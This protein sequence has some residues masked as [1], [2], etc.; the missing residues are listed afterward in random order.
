LKALGLLVL[1]Q[2]A[3]SGMLVTTPSGS[4]QILHLPFAKVVCCSAEGQCS[5]SD[6]NYWL[7][8]QHF[9]WT[10]H[11]PNNC[12]GLLFFFLFVFLGF[13]SLK[14]YFIVLI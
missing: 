10:F 6:G 14:L 7:F 8:N 3:S 9:P 5:F 1:S 13:Y 2:W 12:F 4:G 11:V